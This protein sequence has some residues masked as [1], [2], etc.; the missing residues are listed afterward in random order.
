M[1][2]RRL[3]ETVEA[4]AAAAHSRTLMDEWLLGK[5]MAE[6]LLGM[7]LDEGTARYIVSRINW[8]ITWQGWFE[9]T[10]EDAEFVPADFW[11]KLLQ[12]T[13][14][15][16]YLQINRY[17]DVL[18]Y[19]GESMASLLWWLEAVARLAGVDV[20]E[21]ME[22]LRESAAASGYQVEKLLGAEAE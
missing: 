20:A 21:K 8:L 17:N 5:L 16:T 4:E 12:D 3:G 13:D 9:P 6:A 18:W 19:N 11:R 15:R 10:A 14:I 1:F 22:L 7:G 2:V